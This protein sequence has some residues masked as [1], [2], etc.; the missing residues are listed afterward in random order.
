MDQLK[1]FNIEKNEL[2]KSRITIIM[3]DINNE[4]KVINTN[5]IR[6]NIHKKKFIYKKPA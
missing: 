3:Q 4:K 1:K 2:V 6:K 5:L